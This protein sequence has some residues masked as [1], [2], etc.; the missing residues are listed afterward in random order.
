[1]SEQTVEF[2]G[3]EPAKPEIRDFLA[4]YLRYLPWVLVCMVIAMALAY[5]KI[6]YSVPIYHVQSTMMVKTDGPG[7]GGKD[8]KLN[9][10]FMT[11]PM[12]NLLDEIAFLK[13]SPVLARVVRDLNLQTSYY[14]RGSVK[15]SIL[16]RQTP[17]TFHFLQNGDSAYG[18]GFQITAIDDR[19][20]LI[21]QDKAVNYFGQPFKIGNSICML[22]RNM[23]LDLKMYQSRNYSISWQPAI[24]VARGLAGAVKIVQGNE[25][26]SLLT[27]SMES[28]S[29]ELGVDLLNTVMNVYDSLIVEDKKRI[30]INT[31]NFIDDRVKS[32][33]DS[34]GDVEGTLSDFKATNQTFDIGDQAKTYMSDIAA[35]DKDLKTRETDMIIL[36]WLINYLNEPVNTYK[37]VPVNLG[38]NEATL[39]TL[40]GEYNRSVLERESN[41]K[42]TKPDNPMIKRLEA[43]MDKMKQNM[44]AALNNVKEAATITNNQIAKTNVELQGRLKTMPRKSI[45]EQAIVH[46]Q[47]ILQELYYF[48]MQKKLETSISSASTISNSKVVEP[49]L[50]SDVPV[51]PNNKSIYTS[52][53]MIGLLI[54]AVLIAIIEVM[55]DKVNNRIEIQKA[56]QTPILGEVGH[57]EGDRTLVVSTNSRGFIAEQFRIIR[58]NL[59]YIVG[60]NERP[61]ILV[62]S[63]FS[64]E[65]KSFVSTNMG[66]V[67]ALA[68][69]KTV[70]MEFDIR[71]PKIVSGLDLKRKMG[72]TNYIIGSAR[73]EDLLVKVD[74]VDDFYVIPCGPIP[75]NPAELLLS[76]RLKELIETAKRHFEVIILDTAPVGLVS[77]ALT[78][79]QY[80][81]CTLYIVRRGH[82]PRRLLGLVN[83]LYNNKKLPSM[84]VILNDVKLQG[85]YYGGYGYYGYYG[86]GYGKNNGYFE[87]GSGR[88]G[89]FG[90][91]KSKKDSDKA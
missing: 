38:I 52:Y 41:L 9:A 27:L 10:L 37:A 16:Y 77:D 5:V 70:V 22:T 21:N 15:S 28:E 78:L 67:M 87:S 25:Y 34:L 6:R 68:G 11:E 40:F 79:S 69:K 84:S 2:V 49:A 47:Q 53:L 72:I 19:Q 3:Q 33:K 64:G 86:Y 48:L 8:D 65:G 17:I 83:E 73:F 71:K 59:Q 43:G 81:D 35:S 90:R 46:Q 45:H 57:S 32:L 88:K 14:C 7:S 55:N 13:S 58:T 36:N 1:M 54:P 61:V 56:T 75:P 66:A 80:A 39:S 74:G 31:A 29:M 76:P 18:I 4:R 89:L 91:K 30:A 44:L 85:G 62:T 42:T 63:S 23:N 20:F 60:K 51:S 24:Q 26:S 12:T 82:T 50:G